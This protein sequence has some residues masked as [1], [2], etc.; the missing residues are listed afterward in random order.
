MI[1]IKIVLIRSRYIDSQKDVAEF[2]GIKNTS[3]KAI[4]RRCRVL[5][6]E[7]EF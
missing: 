1:R 2:L 6:F 3:K 7:V 4:E 5:S